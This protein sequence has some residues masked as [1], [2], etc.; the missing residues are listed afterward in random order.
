[1]KLI[2]I[3]PALV[4]LAGFACAPVTLS[5]QTT[6]AP[7]A[8][9]EAATTNAPT[10]TAPAKPKTTAPKTTAYSGK[11]T[12]I[13]STA[14][15][16]T[17]ASSK[18]TLTLAVASTTK[19][20]KDKVKAALADLAVGEKVTGSYTKDSTGAMTAYSI[21]YKTPTPTASTKP[22]SAATTT[23][24]PSATPAAPAAQ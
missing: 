20:L 22:A 19:I 21:H 15:T 6:N 12:A 16:I 7:A 4:A 9:P 3:V 11:I 24:A 1:M 10:A 18:K 23:N 17:V 13:D 2:R 14:N 8:A 5:A